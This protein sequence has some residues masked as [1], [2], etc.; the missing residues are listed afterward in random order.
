M[1]CVKSLA[2][3]VRYLLQLL[4][5]LHHPWLLDCPFAISLSANDGLV[6]RERIM[7]SHILSRGVARFAAQLGA[8]TA[9]LG[10][11]LGGAFGQE[12]APAPETEGVEVLTRGV[13]HEAF[14]EVVTDP[15]P[16]LIVPKR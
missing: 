16:G 2:V 14:A 12:V 8:L 11:L 1:C 15:R 10:A 9:L 6:S 3:Q 13:V 4:Y 7:S 5:T